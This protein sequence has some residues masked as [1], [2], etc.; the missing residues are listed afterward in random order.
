MSRQPK[1]PSLGPARLDTTAIQATF[2]AASKDLT[3]VEITSRF[4]NRSVFRRLGDYVN[5]KLRLAPNHDTPAKPPPQPRPAT[6]LILSQA[7]TKKK[8]LP[9][10]LATAIVSQQLALAP[11]GDNQV[12]SIDRQTLLGTRNGAPDRN[13]EDGTKDWSALKSTLKLLNGLTGWFPPLQSATEGLISCLEIIEAVARNRSDYAELASNLNTIAGSLMSHLQNTKSTRMSD[14]IVNFSRGIQQE[15]EG[16]KGQQSKS[17]TRRSA[18]IHTQE[19]DLIKRYRRIDALF[20]QLELDARLSLWSLYDEDSTN[21]RLDGL[22]PAKLAH[23][24]ST[25]S[26]QLDRHPCARQTCAEVLWKLQ[27]WSRDMHAAKVR[28]MTGMPG[29]GKTTIAYS[30]AEALEGRRQ[31]AA[32]FFCARGSPECQDAN[33]IIPTIAYQL[34]RYSTPFQWELYRILG[35]A[36]D[37]SSQKISTQFNRLLKDPLISV[38]GAIPDNVVVIIDALDECA[39]K[40]SVTQI[41]DL[42]LKHGPELPLKF[43]ITSRP[44]ADIHYRIINHKDSESYCSITDLRSVGQSMVRKDIETYLQ[45]KLGFLSPT[46]SQIEQLVQRSGSLFIY[47]ATIVRYIQPDNRRARHKERFDSI[48]AMTSA[49]TSKVYEK[50]DPLYAAV[51]QSVFEEANMDTYDEDAVRRVLWTVLCARESIDVDTIRALAGLTDKQQ[52]VHA[53]ESLASVISLSE[54][55]HVSTLHT[56]F[57]EF[58]FDSNRSKSLCCKKEQYNGCLT[59]QCFELM[60][61]QLRF[62]ICDLESP[63]QPDES[64]P[65]IKSRI[66]SNISPALLYACRYWVDHL[67]SSDSSSAYST[68]INDF[69]S[70]RLLF[71]MEVLNLKQFINE[72]EDV[73]FKAMTWLKA[74]NSSSDIIKLAEDSRNFVTGFAAN[75][76]SICTPH[77]YISALPF[78]HRLSAVFQHY[79]RRAPGL[80]KVKGSLME[81]RRAAPL[82]SSSWGKKYISSSFA[83]SPDGSLLAVGSIGGEGQMISVRNTRGVD[84]RSPFQVLKPSIQIVALALSSDAKYVACASDDFKVQVWDVRNGVPAISPFEGHTAA[85]NSLSFSSEGSHIASGSSDRTIRVHHLSGSEPM[86]FR[87]SGVGAPIKSVSFSPNGKYIVSGADNSEILLWNVEKHSPISNSSQFRGHTSSVNSV[88]FSPDGQSIASGSSDCTI[89]I[90]SSPEGQPKFQLIDRSGSNVHG[91]IDPISSVGFSPDGLRIVSASID[92][93]IRVWETQSGKLITGPFEGPCQIV[94]AAFSDDGTRVISASQDCTIQTWNA[95]CGVLSDNATRDDKYAITAVEI[96]PNGQQIVTGCSDGTI[97][98]WNSRD[99]AADQSPLRGHSGAV[100]TL[101]WSPDNSI[102]ASGSDDHS[103]RVWDLQKEAGGPAIS[104]LLGHEDWVWSVSFSPDGTKIVSG[105]NDC[106]I[107]V[108]STFTGELLLGPLQGLPDPVSIAVFS[109]DG[110]SIISGSNNSVIR[111]HKVDGG[112]KVFEKSFGEQ[113]TRGISLTARVVQSK[114][115]DPVVAALSSDETP[116]TSGPKRPTIRTWSI[117]NGTGIHE[118]GAA[119]EPSLTSPIVRSKATGLLQSNVARSKKAI[120]EANHPT[121]SLDFTAVAFSFDTRQVAFGCGD[122]SIHVWNIAEHSPAVESLQGHTSPASS[123]AFSPDST[124]LVSAA[125]DGTVRVWDV[126][127]GVA[128]A[129][130]FHPATTG[131]I[132]SVCFSPDGTSVV[133]GCENSTVFVWDICVS[134]GGVSPIDEDEWNV[135]DDGWVI[136]PKSERLFWVPQDIACYKPTQRTK[137]VIGPH[138]AICIDHQ[139]LLKGHDWRQFDSPE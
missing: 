129:G 4:G 85:I 65:L 17:A 54:D 118:A 92:S 113:S 135:E 107:R 84:I 12:I 39:N 14:C 102:I 52:V 26:E 95:H 137:L 49:S 134:K 66:D 100:R 3:A 36:P 123:L 91:H 20:K 104:P 43:F 19:E 77:I 74:R 29:T 93:T 112:I 103:I 44:D 122:C 83:F 16:I 82:A 109:S 41:V 117:A 53:L 114:V 45:D 37:L 2:S 115:A 111:I 120:T 94:A 131:A 89:R 27:S 75:K 78:C 79:S 80:L 21:K 1:G 136:T 58:M 34:A 72:G 5:R 23:Y 10:S 96:G 33:R 119:K 50:I 42:L 127:K 98:L 139:D 59:K 28:W 62:N 110:A 101:A 99:G 24:N 81:W 87:K 8:L 126:L 76:L 68:A 105:S 32:T 125:P 31:L 132:L 51:V 57:I 86:I 70:H 47:A 64:N 18:E 25:L 124:K 13:R 46:P 63:H 67:G 48:L 7:V 11:L 121:H 15:L 60:K 9:V 30:F 22:V 90:W 97:R 128:V 106:T 73:L 35:Q 56:S 138:G 38:K 133:S 61:D 116:T 130:P 40:R 108:W 71:W 69:L 55:E 6:P 88:A